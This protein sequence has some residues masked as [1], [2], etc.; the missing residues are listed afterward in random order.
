MF[1]ALLTIFQIYKKIKKIHQDI[2]VVIINNKMVCLLWFHVFSYTITWFRCNAF[3]SFLMSFHLWVLLTDDKGSDTNLTSNIV[4]KEV[5]QNVHRLLL[6]LLIIYRNDISYRMSHW[7][8]YFVVFYVNWQWLFHVYLCGYR[9]PVRNTDTQ[10]TI[11][12]LLKWL[13]HWKST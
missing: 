6:L 8:S 10:S 13:R 9:W 2:E 3:K 12:Y 7:L 11:Q 4:Y 5:F 1:Y